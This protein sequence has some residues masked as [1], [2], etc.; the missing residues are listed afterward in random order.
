MT[1]VIII[2]GL[3]G[4]GSTTVAKFLAEDLGLEHVYAG[5]LFRQ[6]AKEAGMTL[7]AFNEALTNDPDRERAFDDSLI[8]RAREGSVII[9][10]R[11][12]GWLLPSDVAAYKAWLTCEFT[13]R[14]RRINQRDD[15]PDSKE[16]ILR[17]E[18]SEQERYEALY[19]I[20]MADFSVF[21]RVIDTT[22]TPAREV[23]NSILADL[24]A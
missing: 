17:R 7:E 16:L 1:D 12:L 23:A 22:K 24:T 8:N 15:Y 3:P 6:M 5:G 20:N 2:N 21:D 11:T 13:E 19:S 10:S 14:V 18:R 9:E 4:T